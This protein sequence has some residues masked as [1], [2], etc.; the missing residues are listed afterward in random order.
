MSRLKEI[1]ERL[2][3]TQGNMADTLGLSLRAY[4]DIEL[5]RAKEKLAYVLAA[6]RLAMISAVSRG[7]ISLASA[8][9]RRLALD[10]AKLI[11]G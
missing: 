3:V 9:S 2:G 1:R 10:L 11:T 4:S 8:E 5:G 6:E 7:D